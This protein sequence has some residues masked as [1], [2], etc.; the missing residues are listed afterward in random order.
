VPK[1]DVAVELFYDGSW[2]DI[3][4]GDKVFADAPVTIRRGLG[5]ESGGWPRP[6]QITARFDNATD[7]Y[8]TSNPESPLYGKAGRNTPM[9]VSV[10]GTV[11]GIVEASSW[12]ADQTPDFRATPRR[13]LSWVDVAG[14]GLLQRIGQ[15]T[16]PLRSALYRY[17]DK[18]G[19]TPAEWW[20]MEDVDGS[21][22]A[23]SAA[24]GTALIPVTAV[25]YTLPD[26]SPLPPGGAPKF[27]SGK[28]ISGSAALPSFQGGGTLAAPIRSTTFNGYAIDWV[29][30]FQAGTDEGGTT[31]GDVLSWRESGTYVHFTVNVTKDFVTV[32]HA[33]ETDDATLASTGSATASLDVYDGTPHH[34]RYQVR[35]N[36]SNYKAELYIDG[37]LYATAD[38]FTPGMAGT[39]GRPTSIE[40]NPGEL[41]GDYMPI[42]AGHL[43]V[44]AS[45][46]AGGQPA[47][48]EALNGRA[49]EKAAYRFGRLM[50]E[51]LGAGH[52]FVS[53][54]FDDS[55]PMGPQRVDSLPNLLKECI[56]TEDAIV[57]DDGDDVRPFFLCRADR[58]NQTPALTLTTSDLTVLPK[59]VTD[60]K[61]TANVVTASQ[62]EGGDWTARDD[63]GPLGTLPPPDGVGDAKKTV[64]VN[65]DDPENDLPQVANWW[66]R[67]GTVDLPR[68]PQLTIDLNAKPGL[69]AD[70]EAVLPGSVIT[71]TGFRENVIRLYVLGWTETIGT[72]SR[73]ITFTC[74]PDQQYDVGIFGVGSNVVRYDSASSVVVNAPTASGT[75]VKIGTGIP[76]DK[77]STTSV[78][79]DV[80]ISGER[81]TVTA[82]GADAGGTQIIS[83]TF[84]SGTTGWAAS[85]GS[86]AQSG[87]FAHG[88]SFSGLLTVSG[89]PSQSYIRPSQA[90][91]P[92]VVPGAS[93]TLGVWVRSA[94]NLPDV[95]ATI[96]WLDEAGN[97]LSKSDSAGALTSGS[98]VQ[99][100]VTA[101]APDGARYLQYGAT[102]SSSPSAG[103]LL[104]ID[105]ITITSSSARFQDATVTRGVN[106]VNKALPPGSE[107]HVAT[108]GRWAL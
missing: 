103:T 82:M 31:S 11:R 75:F 77:W 30:Q 91:S 79:Y 83:G 43:V 35:Q 47:L 66:L 94:V 84:E 70:V 93:Y 33:N 41:R 17:V 74:A 51:E 38:N 1:Q 100:T 24:G 96:D 85:G 67:K 104:Y 12:T 5:D 108:P 78:P 102:I 48:Y 95:R 22:A 27:A 7:K 29:M 28:G 13:G 34:F 61:G 92:A 49:G 9:R 10:G 42:A 64:D 39:V 3:V 89:S 4:T 88:G 69:I 107:V 21:P 81:V 87:T 32:F 80:M 8:R 105:D 20:P 57:Y 98:W 73:T 18:S 59:E 71:L 45:G 36:S 15:W 97:F 44:W 23:V 68:F 6:A 40:W 55:M 54:G 25:R 76:S 63:T 65:L 19:V 14:G 72:H 26:G 50:D 86:F 106:G 53:S 101:T 99:R 52:Y 16:Q 62:R 60:D 58:Y 56:T 37:A 2:H 90:S 46:Q